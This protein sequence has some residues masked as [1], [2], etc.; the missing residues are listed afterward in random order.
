[1]IFYY[2]NNIERT[3]D[4]VNNTLKIE[5]QIQRRSDSCSFKIF[6][7]TKPS[8]N[9]N[10]R[11]YDGAL[12]ESQVGATIVLKESYQEEISAFRAGQIIFLDLGGDLERA[13]IQSYTESTRTIVLT[14]APTGT[15]AA[16]EKIGELIFGGTVARVS[17]ANRHTLN[18]IE[19]SITGVD[20]T[21]IFDKK[22]I[23]DSW[24]EVDC[25]YIINDFVN[26]T[27]NYNTTIDN[28]S[29]ANNGAIQAEWI[30]S[31]DGN[32]PTIDLS[33]FI[34]S[35]SSGVFGWTNAGGTA[36]FAATPTS[37][38]ISGFVGASA[39]SPTQGLLMSWFKTS[40]QAAITTLKIR[41]G[42]DS[43][44]YAEFTISLSSSTD[45]QYH[46]K[47]FNQATIV[48]NPNWTAV[49][50]AAIVIT[51][52]ATGTVRWNGLRVN[53]EKSFTLN[54]VQPTPTI[55]DIR[56]P[57][58]KPTNFI[59][60]L[61]KNFEYLWY[62]DY[63]Q[64]IH[65]VD[66]EN[67]PAPFSL[68]TTSDNFFDL[69]MEVD[70]SNLGNRIIIRGGE[71]TS[72]SLY[73]QVFEGDNAI[74]EWLMKTKFNNLSITIDNNTT[75]H[76]AE[77]GTTT[78]NIKITGHSLSTGDHITNRTR[79]NTVRQITKVDNDNFTVETVTG[80]T[81]GDTISY[82]SIAKTD[83]VEGLTDEATVD[84]VANSNEK[85]IRATSIE[86]T[87]PTGTFIRFSYNE[88]VPIQI[89][90]TDPAS[91]NSLKAMGLGDGVFDL[92]PITDRNIKD[93]SQ[94]IIIA[95][96]KVREFG[97]PIIS[98]SFITDFKGLRAGQLLQITETTR[99]VDDTYV[100][101]KISKS[102]KDGQFKDNLVYKVSFGTTLFGWIEFMQ[103]LLK[104][105]Q[106][107]ELNVDDI[108]ETFV[109]SNETVE[110]SEVSLSQ[111]GGFK[112]ATQTET[113]TSDDSNTIHETTVPWQWEPSVGQT[114]ATRWSL[115]EWG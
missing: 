81:N 62:I 69:K 85:S 44:N 35:I 89:Q 86:P 14:A 106:G 50:Y 48:G 26:S 95:E 21:K 20:F 100:I 55:D 15:F 47:R 34:E 61:A 64:D 40:S 103:K 25:R 79:S 70:T 83:G 87:L 54:N 84:Y 30:E 12:I 13:I 8:E 3:S 16:D 88:R 9:Q 107:I 102:Q 101:Q 59:D 94:A 2:I 28:L 1:M 7:N 112:T 32:N 72:D 17:D 111:K 27:I 6:Q 76:A 11:I 42:S 114:V 4:V 74:R 58:L 52:T 31:G 37:K 23:S 71:K 57:Q 109:D 90:Y 82:F 92:D 93:L 5:N 73:A 24:Q 19:Y 56:A 115:F 108:V 51:E 68:T 10:L 98:G 53:A 36:T 41:L 97:N 67:D 29:Y 80:Q 91:A 110:A 66:S 18:N 49:D 104:E 43:T 96:A 105:K 63:E 60:Q 38:D 78:T 75:T 65:F 113:V 99:S 39:G 45:W 77:V 46:S 22:I 33:S